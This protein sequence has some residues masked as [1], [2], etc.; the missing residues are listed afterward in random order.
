MTPKYS[1][2]IPFYNVKPYVRPC[3]DSVLA[4]TF[5]DWE[6]ICVDDGSP[7]GLGEILDE[8]AAKDCRFKVIHQPNAGVGAARNAAL[9]AMSG[10]WFFFV[11]GDDLTS[12]WTCEMCESAL[13]A[14]PDADMLMFGDT[15]FPQD[16]VCDWGAGPEGMKLECRDVSHVVDLWMYRTGHCTRA[17]RRSAY[18]EFRNPNLIKGQDRYFLLDC[19]FRTNKMVKVDRPISGVRHRIGSTMRSAMTVKKLQAAITLS[20]HFIGLVESSER[21]IDSA[22]VRSLVNQYMETF[23]EALGQL[24]DKGEQVFVFRLWLEMVGRLQKSRVTKGFQQFRAR[25]L[26]LLPFR[27]T[28]NLLCLLP[29]KIKCKGFHR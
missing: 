17:Y 9:S 24:Q 19:L 4:Q 10:E 22:F 29:H 2:I 6:C 13:K 8:Y 23:V 5:S 14:Q 15:S 20:E 26:L 11:D 3:L 18:G 25:I 27:L 28:A 12:P 16:G 21:Q 1:Y 7:D